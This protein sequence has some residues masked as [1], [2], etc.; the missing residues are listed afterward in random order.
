MFVTVR[1]DGKFLKG[2]NNADVLFPLLI[3]RMGDG[4]TMGNVVVR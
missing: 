3:L 4:V 2:D 1:E